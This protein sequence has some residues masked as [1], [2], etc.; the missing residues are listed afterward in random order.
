MSA[1]QETAAREGGALRIVTGEGFRLFFLS[2]AAF[3]VLS[4]AAWLLWLGVHAAGGAFRSLPFA[5]APHLWHAHEMVFGYAGAV[6][7]GF[8]LTAVPSW[9]GTPPARPPFLIAAF[10]IWLAGRAAVWWSGALDPLLVAA[11]DLAFLPL[12][13]ANVLLRLARRPKPQNFVLLGL[14]A[15]IWCGNLSVHLEWTEVAGDGAWAGLRAGLLAVAALISVIGGRVTPAFTRDAM[16]QAGEAERLPRSDPRATAVAIVAAVALPLLLLAGAPDWLA[17]SAAGLCG[18]AQA[19]RLVGWRTGWTRSRPILWSLHLGFAM[20]AL[21]YLWLG[22]AWAGIGS[23]IAALHVLG[24]GA[25]GGMT[26][27]VMSRAALGHTGRRLSLPAPIVLAF[28]SIALSALLRALGSSG[29]LSWYYL[30]VIGSGALWI[31]AF[32]AFLAVFWGP[33]TGPKC[34]D[35]T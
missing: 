33:L 18:A 9:T 13:A 22:L 24:I 11:L 25:I 5:P 16:L 26:L 4:V 12:I 10:C 34:R 20:L 6:I 32:A 27:A 35:L 19:V 28:L 3:A 1:R 8:F 14:L 30:A 17:A 23:E 21:G 29:G 31:A 7:A 15:L 2:A